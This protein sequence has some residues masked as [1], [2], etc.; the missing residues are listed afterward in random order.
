MTEATR[1]GLLDPLIPVT[2][3]TSI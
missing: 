2:T 3:P 1:Q